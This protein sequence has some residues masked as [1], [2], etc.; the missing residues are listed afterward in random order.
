MPDKGG[1]NLGPLEEFPVDIFRIVEVEGREIGILRRRDGTTH[2][3][4][5]VCPHRS[6][7]ICLG[8]YGG[9]WLPGEPGDLSYG[10]EWRVI[11]CPWHGWEFDIETGE[12]LFG[13]SKTRLLIYR[14]WTDET[15]VFVDLTPK[16]REEAVV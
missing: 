6:G 4:L 7:P 1:I 11:Q 12:N 10:H 14:A 13:V 3:V 8:R 15:S 2:A 16:P 9:S 5:N